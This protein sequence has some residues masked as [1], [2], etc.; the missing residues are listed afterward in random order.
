MALFR[1]PLRPLTRIGRVLLAV[2]VPVCATLMLLAWS[3]AQAD[4]H[5]QLRR[6]ADRGARDRPRLEAIL[7]GCIRFR[8]PGARPGSTI[9]APGIRRRRRPAI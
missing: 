6:A 7:A 1:F 9:C 8:A 3:P 5:A 2:A 4:P